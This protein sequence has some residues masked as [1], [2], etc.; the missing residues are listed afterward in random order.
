[1]PRSGNAC[2]IAK[3]ALGQ[4]SIVDHQHFHYNTAPLTESILQTFLPVQCY[5]VY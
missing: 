2:D 5:P 4:S 1:M 3:D